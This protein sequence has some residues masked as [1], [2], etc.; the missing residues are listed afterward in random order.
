MNMLPSSPG[1]QNVTKRNINR[2]FSICGAISSKIVWVDLNFCMY[3]V[4]LLG[5]LEVKDFKCSKKILQ[6]LGSL[7]QMPV[8]AS[9]SDR[10]K[11]G[12]DQLSFLPLTLKVRQ[13][14]KRSKKMVYNGW[15]WCLDIVPAW[16]WSFTISCSIME[17]R[18]PIFRLIIRFQPV[19]GQ[20]LLSWHLNLG[21]FFSV[22]DCRSLLSTCNSKSR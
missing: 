11:I 3:F 1:L 10:M 7:L 21:K 8:L 2:Y 12:K 14:A 17:A 22:V 5:D 6:K 15:W 18:L 19:A 9:S 16:H 4:L 13:W 20:T